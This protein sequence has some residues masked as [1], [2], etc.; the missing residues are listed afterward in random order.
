MGVSTRELVKLSARVAEE[1]KAGDLVV[2][3]LKGISSVTDYFMI[4]SGT[5]D[6]NVRAIA[7][8]VR[9]KLE[10]KG[11]R[12]LG[13]EGYSDGTWILLDYVDFV[14]HIFHYEKRVIYALEDLWSDAKQVTFRRAAKTI[15]EAP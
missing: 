7:D 6:T 5:S 4:C 10:E 8:T 14:L 2:L 1:K 11:I 15:R 12:A 9:E 3:D 13:V